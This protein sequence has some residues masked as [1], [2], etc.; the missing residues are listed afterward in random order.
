MRIGQHDAPALA[1]NPQ[2]ILVAGEVGQRL[3]AF[4]AHS[5]HRTKAEH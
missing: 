2:K 5:T 4:A 1:L 3:K